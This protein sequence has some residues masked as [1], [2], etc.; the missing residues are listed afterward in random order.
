MN[1]EDIEIIN[2]DIDDTFQYGG[3][4]FQGLEDLKKSA[5]ESYNKKD[6][7]KRPPYVVIIDHL[8]PCFDSEDYANENRYFQNY[9]LT[10]DSAKA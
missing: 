10:T 3:R 2:I 5:F 6:K 1:R 7:M 4:T 8:Y 9:Y